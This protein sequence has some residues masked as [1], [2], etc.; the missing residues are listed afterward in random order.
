M[1]AIRYVH[2]VDSLMHAM[3]SIRPEIVTQLDWSVDF[4]AT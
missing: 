3:A 4:S 2:V 1:D